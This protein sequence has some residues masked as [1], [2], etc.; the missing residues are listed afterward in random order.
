M[1]INQKFR[2]LL[3]LLLL[4]ILIALLLKGTFEVGNGDRTN[5]PT[6][7]LHVGP[8]KTGTTYIQHTLWEKREELALIGIRYITPEHNYGI[9]HHFMQYPEANAARVAKVVD[10][11]KAMKQKFGIIS[12]EA[13]SNCKSSDIEY[14]RSKLKDVCNVKVVAFIRP[15]YLALV[16]SFKQKLRSKGQHPTFERY[17]YINRDTFEEFVKSNFISKHIKVPWFIEFI[18]KWIKV[19]EMKNVVLVDYENTKNNGD[20]LNGMLRSVSAPTLT[21]LEEQFEKGNL[22]LWGQSNSS[23]VPYDQMYVLYIKE[24]MRKYQCPGT[25]LVSD[26]TKISR[27]ISDTM[28]AEY[29]QSLPLRSDEHLRL[30]KDLLNHDKGVFGKYSEIMFNIDPKV[31]EKHTL[32]APTLVT[33]DVAELQSAPRFKWSD[34][35][36]RLFA[37]HG[38]SV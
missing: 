19:F 12:S 30:K 4:V 22:T 15:S 37:I 23:A 36:E 31:G 9:A 35:V 11:V 2:F 33:L 18:D 14:I 32:D 24:L 25:A 17:A 8:E 6:V 16:S 10:E 3:S 28:R 21:S 26:N 29:G 38:C 13:M 1:N 34:L 5:L 7:V 27:N 20:I